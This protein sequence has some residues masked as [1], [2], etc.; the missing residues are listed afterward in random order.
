MTSYNRMSKDLQTIID[1]NRNVVLSLFNGR[2]I[3]NP[4]HK[5]VV[6]H[7]IEPKSLRPN[8]WWEID[9]MV[10]LCAICHDLI[11]ASG[12]KTYQKQ[13]QELRNGRG[14]V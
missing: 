9:N 14:K 6:I 3:L 4:A 1:A 12:A 8:D 2:C 5:A 13:L 7:E 10:P 11:H